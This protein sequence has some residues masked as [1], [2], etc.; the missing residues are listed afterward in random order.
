M[1]QALIGAKVFDGE[2]FLND[3]AVIIDRDKIIELAPV[4]QLD[5]NIEKIN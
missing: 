3:T 4:S 5:N 1:K 2:N